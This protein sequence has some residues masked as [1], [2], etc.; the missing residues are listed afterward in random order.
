MADFRGGLDA[1]HARHVQ[2]HEDA[3]ERGIRVG[4][5]EELQGFLSRRRCDGDRLDV[6]QKV[7]DIIGLEFVVIDDKDPCP[8]QIRIVVH[9]KSLSV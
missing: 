8:I 4:V 7:G 5:R 9:D 1:V 2:V 3:G 6:R